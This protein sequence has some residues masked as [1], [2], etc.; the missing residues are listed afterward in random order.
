MGVNSV[1]DFGFN[2]CNINRRLGLFFLYNEG[3]ALTTDELAK[4]E[5]RCIAGICNLADMQVLIDAVK[6]QAA[7]CEMYQVKV[8]HQKLALQAMYNHIADLA[9]NWRDLTMNVPS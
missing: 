2:R 7:A 8:D 4:I 1:N 9:C 3:Y 6:Q 5:E